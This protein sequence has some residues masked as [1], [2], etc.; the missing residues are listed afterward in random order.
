[1]NTIALVLFAAMLFSPPAFASINPKIQLV[2]YSVSESPAEPG[3]AISLTLHLK[4]ME[5]DNCADRVAVQLVVPYPFSIRGSDT[6]YLDSLCFQDPDTKGDFTFILPVDNLATSGT[7]QVSVA[8]TY[9]KRFT[10]LSEGNTL[11]L[12]V[13]G[14]PSFTAAVVSSTP[15]DIYPGDSAQV[16]VAFQ[17][18]GSSSVQSARA[19]ADSRGIVVKW[20]GREQ[21]LGEILARGSKRATFTIEAPKDLRA[22][23]YP[24]R[25]HLDYTAQDRTDGT[26]DFTFNVPVKPQAEFE[27]SL[28]SGALLPGEKR[29]VSIALKNTGSEEARK[30][31]V[32]IKPLF[33][34][35]TDGTVRYIDSLKPGEAKN[36]AYIITVDKDA[37]SGG[38]LLGLL[39][40]FESPQGKKFSGS[41][42]FALP[43]RLPTVEEEAKNYWYALAIA[44]VIVLII[45]VRKLRGKKPAGK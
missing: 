11:N 39:V 10:K 9:E 38:Q 4:S 31:Q 3:H 45:V 32:R 24:L 2:N 27:A 22:G 19:G 14:A 15:V 25:V 36:L 29:E 8:T 18:T 37:A 13:G 43:V 40:D 17:N 44:G 23:T 28:P 30:V 1:M 7:Y 21:D 16:T 42:D 33:P 34:F 41:A 5:S 12:Q 6:Q 20:S 26:V 35:S